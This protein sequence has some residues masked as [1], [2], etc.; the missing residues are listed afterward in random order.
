MSPALW[1]GPC[2]TSGCT[3]PH[4]VLFCFQLT[5]SAWATIPTRIRDDIAVGKPVQAGRPA[6]PA[7]VKKKGERGKA[8]VA[9]VE[10][11]TSATSATALRAGAVQPQAA[12]EDDDEGECQGTAS[13]TPAGQRALMLSVPNAGE[14]VCSDARTYAAIMCTASSH[15]QVSLCAWEGG[16]IP[17]PLSAVVL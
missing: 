6:H 13:A 14:S 8:V 4:G 16:G 15:L 12:D 5:P 17:W 10:S 9:K 2:S 3:D 11:R 7:G 1:Q